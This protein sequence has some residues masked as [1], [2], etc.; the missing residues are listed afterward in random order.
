MF[1]CLTCDYCT[2]AKSNLKRHT[3]KKS[4]CQ[5]PETGNTDRW[6]HLDTKYVKC[7]LCCKRVTCAYKDKHVQACKGVPQ[8][9]CVYCKRSFNTRSGKSRHAKICRNS[10][11]PE[12]PK[13]TSNNT[14]EVIHITNNHITNNITQNNHIVNLTVNFGSENIGYLLNND[15]GRVKQALSYIMDA[16]DLVHFNRDHPENQT[17]R[18]LNKKSDMMEIK[19]NDVWEHES[20]E[21]GIPRLKNNLQNHLSLSFEDRTQYTHPHIK[22]F[23]Y[24]KSKRGNLPENVILERYAKENNHIKCSDECE[25]IK[26]SFLKTVSP[27]IQKTPC[28]VQNLQQQ[29][30]K[31]RVKFDQTPFTVRNVIEFVF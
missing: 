2:N 13:P 19:K 27:G 21:I 22:E 31:V 5:K 23:L 3:N 20:C 25:R 4:P 1:K 29:L 8:N 26:V 15:D 9:E 7:V 16:I 12:Q 28:V 17:V 10:S 11:I 18:K 14:K 6:E 30:N 24:H